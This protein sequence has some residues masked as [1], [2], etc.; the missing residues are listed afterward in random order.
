[1][2]SPAHP[3][4]YNKLIDANDA[5]ADDDAAADD[6]GDNDGDRPRA[7]Y[8]Q[9]AGMSVLGTLASQNSAEGP[10]SAR[11]SAPSTCTLSSRYSGLINKNSPAK[12][13]R[14]IIFC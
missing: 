11:V 14:C 5:D 1:M 7:N 2:H 8:A 9:R 6:D 10:F 3:T 13:R 12:C 4:P